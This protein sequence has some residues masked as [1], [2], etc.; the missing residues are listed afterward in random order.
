MC[1]QNINSQPY[2]MSD[3]REILGVARCSA[4]NEGK[5]VVSSGILEPPCCCCMIE[6]SLQL[7]VC[8]QEQHP[9]IYTTCLPLM[10]TQRARH[11]FWCYTDGYHSHTTL[12]LLA[13]A[14]E[15]WQVFQYAIFT[16]TVNDVTPLFASALSLL[17]VATIFPPH[18]CC[19]PCII[20]SWVQALTQCYIPT[21]YVN[22]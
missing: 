5:R 4:A 16:T 6:V 18:C 8:P 17:Q 1:F 15:I 21:H 19:Q 13:I 9:I 22:V 10:L 2:S 7:M 12:L 14:H 20:R 11:C 3:S